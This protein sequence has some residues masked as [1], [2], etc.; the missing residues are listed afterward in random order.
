[1]PFNGLYGSWGKMLTKK[2]FGYFVYYLLPSFCCIFLAIILNLIIKGGYCLRL[3]WMAEP[4]YYAALFGTFIGM[5][6]GLLLFHFS[7]K[8]GA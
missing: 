8:D 2:Q 5:V 6:S 4:I 1:M 3:C 7:L